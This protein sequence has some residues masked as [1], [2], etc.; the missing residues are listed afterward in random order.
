MA[1][2]PSPLL[3]A[4]QVDFIQ[5][6]DDT[7]QLHLLVGVKRKKKESAK[8]ISI[9]FCIA[10][11]DGISWARRAKGCVCV[12]VCVCVHVF[13]RVSVWLCVCAGSCV[14]EFM[15]AFLPVRAMNY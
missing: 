4:T 6:D 2:L 12:C 15:R 5:L 9:R 11:S 10:R 1:S 7:A 8:I 13:V 14:F 3:I